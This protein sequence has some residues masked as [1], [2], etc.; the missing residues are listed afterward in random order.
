M[1]KVLNG[2]GTVMKIAFVGVLLIG[3]IIADAVGVL[4]YAITSQN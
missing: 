3:H 2:L 4:V 1:R